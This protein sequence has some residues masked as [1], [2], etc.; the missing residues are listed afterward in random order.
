M[1]CGMA[2]DVLALMHACVQMH[3]TCRSAHTQMPKE[4]PPII[5]AEQHSSAQQVMYA[6]VEA[7]KKTFGKP[8]QIIFMLLPTKV[9]ASPCITSVC[10]YRNWR[11]HACAASRKSGAAQK[12]AE[13]YSNT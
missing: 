9:R 1:V 3:A 6:A 4:R 13:C 12:N 5:Y 2:E 7:A 8:P 11:V 10:P